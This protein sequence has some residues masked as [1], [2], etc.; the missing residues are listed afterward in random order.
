MSRLDLLILFMDRLESLSATL[1]QAAAHTAE[2]AQQS[3]RLHLALSAADAAIGTLSATVAANLDYLRRLGQLHERS[4][5]LEASFDTNDPVTN[6]TAWLNLHAEFEHLETAFRHSPTAAPPLQPHTLSNSYSV[7]NIRLKPIR[8]REKKAYKKKLR[9]RL[10]QIYTINPLA[11]SPI[12]ET[13]GIDSWSDAGTPLEQTQ[14]TAPLLT[15][16][17]SPET[18]AATPRVRSNSV[19]DLQRDAFDNVNMMR[20]TN[21]MNR[22]HDESE[23]TLR[24]K[25]LRHFV[26]VN[27]GFHLRPPPPLQETTAADASF[28]K[29]PVFT[30][31]ESQPDFE[32]LDIDQCSDFSYYSPDKLE[33]D[34]LEEDNYGQYLRK[35]RLDLHHILPNVIKRSSS[36][37]SIFARQSSWKFHNPVDKCVAAPTIKVSDDSIYFQSARKES[38]EDGSDKPAQTARF[39]SDVILKDAA[40]P[41]RNAGF[42]LFD[43]ATNSPFTKPS[44]QVAE[45][46]TRPA[47]RIK[48]TPTVRTM[49]IAIATHNQAMR[50]PPVRKDRTDGTHS[51][52]T[53]GPNK[54]R[55]FTHG[56]QSYFKRPLASKVSQNSLH[57]A[58]N[59]NML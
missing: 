21:I 1:V 32:L 22:Y 2:L 9:Y 11:S 55:I 50:Q 24:Y 26:S 15:L 20:S 39:L 38:G 8:C 52:L 36:H 28:T 47:P 5:F 14:Q 57:E 23:E 35:S 40:T 29:T 33:E 18:S 58:L 19:P 53:I 44:I 59:F 10:S 43:F 16:A 41:M 4:F 17:T 27:D 25:R 7:S 49:P 51:S 46:P 30:P 45:S 48:A 13:P 6:Q 12:P 42:S 3:T 34:K 54:T 56:E 31:I 37:D